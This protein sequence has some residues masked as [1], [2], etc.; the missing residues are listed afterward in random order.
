MEGSE[1]IGRERFVTVRPAIFDSY[2]DRSGTYSRTKG[3]V[4]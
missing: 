3:K 1:E 2:L 4:R